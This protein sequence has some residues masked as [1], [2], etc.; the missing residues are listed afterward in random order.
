MDAAQAFIEWVISV[1]GQ[2]IWLDPDIN[3]MPIREDVWQ[4]PEGEARPEL[5]EHFLTTLD[6]VGIR[7]N[8]TKWL[9]VEFGFRY[10]FDAVFADLHEELVS[11]WHELVDAYLA[12]E[13]T[14]EEFEEFAFE[15]GKPLTFT[16]PEP[17]LGDGQEHTYT[18]EY[19]MEVNE[20]MKDTEFSSEMSKIWRD[21]A[22]ERYDRLLD[23]LQ[24]MLG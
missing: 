1:D 16:E 21:A 9:Q 22:R 24:D 10:Y 19:A 14:Q 6:Y 11:F 3:R 7:I 8:D 18:L 4:T 20:R 12:G 17:P 13:I 23:E 2:T 15:M 5:Y